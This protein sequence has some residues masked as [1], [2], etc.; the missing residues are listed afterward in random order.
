MD[1]EKLAAIA[2]NKFNHSLHRKNLRERLDAQLVVTH[3][4]GLFK[5]SLTLMS[6]LQSC[7]DEELFLEDEYHNPIKCDR[8]S[9]LSDLKLAYQFAMNQWHIDFENSKKIRKSSDV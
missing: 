3:N 1:T 8:I 6:F 4:N 7:T 5:A 2:S 9:L